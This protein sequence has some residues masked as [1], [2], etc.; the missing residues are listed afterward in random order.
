MIEKKD[1]AWLAKLA[2]LQLD[3]DESEARRKDMEDILGFACTFA[4]AAAASDAYG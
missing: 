2:K 3:E 4:E 1:I